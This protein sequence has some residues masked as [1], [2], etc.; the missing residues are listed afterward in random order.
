MKLHRLLT[1]QLFGAKQCGGVTRFV[2]VTMS[3]QSLCS[4]IE[5][6]STGREITEIVFDPP[7]PTKHAVLQARKYTEIGSFIHT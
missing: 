2:E 5:R 1:K 6:V 7:L 3:S 4:K